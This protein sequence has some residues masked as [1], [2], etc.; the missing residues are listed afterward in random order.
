[1]NAAL[2]P[3]QTEKSED[4]SHKYLPNSYLT[5]EDTS[6]MS[7]FLEK[8]TSKKERGV[9]AKELFKIVQNPLSKFFEEKLSY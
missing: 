9:R 5:Q 6:S 7:F 8:S 4:G 1:M 3:L 2:L